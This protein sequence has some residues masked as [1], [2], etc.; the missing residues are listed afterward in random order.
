MIVRMRQFRAFKYRM[1]IVRATMGAQV[2]V[3]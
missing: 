3:P 2:E 1:D